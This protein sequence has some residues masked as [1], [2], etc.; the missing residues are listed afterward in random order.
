VHDR[1]VAAQRGHHP[2]A[3]LGIAEAGVDVHTAR[4]YYRVKLTIPLL[5]HLIEQME[6]RFPSETCNLYNGF[7]IIGIF[8]NCKGLD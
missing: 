1:Q 2:D 7:Y 4:N 5:D 3:R 8:L 6:F